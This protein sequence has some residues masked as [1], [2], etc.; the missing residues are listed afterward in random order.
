MK[1]TRARD[2]K[3]SSNLCYLDR[4]TIVLPFLA[5]LLTKDAAS[6]VPVFF[7]TLAYSCADNLSFDQAI[8]IKRYLRIAEICTDVDETNE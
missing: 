8:P 7:P 4:F 5:A 2:V 3:Y 6:N 1:T